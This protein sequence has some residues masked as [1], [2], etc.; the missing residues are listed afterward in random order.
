MWNTMQPAFGTFR[1]DRQ[2]V[3]REPESPARPTC[4]IV[5]AALNEELSLPD[6]VVRIEAVLTNCSY[7]VVFVDDGSTDKTWQV[8]QQALRRRPN[9]Q[10]IRLTRPFGHK[11][12]LW[13][14]LSAARGAATI[15]MNSDGRH[16]ADMFPK[17]IA[18]WRGGARVVEM[19]RCEARAVSPLRN[20]VSR[21]YD[22]ILA[23]IGDPRI[24]GADEDFRLID[25]S[26]V[27]LILQ[28]R[29]PVPALRELV[30]WLGCR[31][32][33]L[34]YQSPHAAGS[35]RSRRPRSL[36][37]TRIIA[38]LG[39]PAPPSLLT[40]RLCFYAGLMLSLISLAA[41]GYLLWTAL[42]APAAAPAWASTAAL[43]A[44]LGGF[45]LLCLGL[46]GRHLAGIYETA[47]DR[48]PFVIREQVMPRPPLQA[49]PPVPF[50]SMPVRGLPRAETMI[51]SRVDSPVLTSS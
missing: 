2:P 36:G 49:R 33:E 14:G 9:W 35:P 40:L 11:A 10:A 15:V 34:P 23:G 20:L 18:C 25:R 45:Q 7:E 24:R 12:A 1:T 44:L 41:F 21:A 17:M 47:W 50:V 28:T 26:I 32:V 8:I 6:L 30:P 37:A 51:R 3:A 39:Q 48:P 16:P 27:D 42:F 5:L 22:R 19:V 29:G 46:I 38:D 31:T 4:S 13:A 43:V